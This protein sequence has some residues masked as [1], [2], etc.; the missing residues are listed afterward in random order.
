[1]LKEQDNLI[2]K[3]TLCADALLVGISFMWAFGLRDDFDSSF[4]HEMPP[5]AEYLPAMLLVIPLWVILLSLFG[6]YE[7]MREKGFVRIFWSIFEASLLATLVFAATS[8]LLKFE[9]LSRTFVLIFFVLTV[10]LLTFEK[11][12]TLNFLRNIRKRG[13]NFHS[14]IIVGSGSRARG[15]AGNVE[16]HP[17]WGFKI[18]GFI[19]E[20]EMLGRSVGSSRVIGTFDN[21]ARILDENVVDE[22]VFI[23][24]RKWLDR[25]ETQVRIC[26]KVGVK[27]TISMD[28]FDTSI[29]KPVLKDLDGWPLLTF[30]STPNDFFFLSL[31]RI[32]DTL[33]SVGGLVMLSPLFLL[34]GVIIKLT[35]PG[36]VFF[37]QVRCG[38][39]GRTFQILKFRT[40]VVDAEQKK[41]D[42]LK[43]NEVGGPVFKIK[44]DPRITSI[45]RLL[46]K[47]SL[48]EL[49]QLIN[50]LRGDMSLVG[51]RPPLPSEVER[52]ERWQRRRLSMRPGITCI[53]E[54]KA[55]NNKDFNV[56]MKMDLEYIDNWRLDLDLRILA[57]TVLAVVKGTGC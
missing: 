55:R 28:I 29:A 41:E 22:V 5:F 40:M 47:T 10:L 13:L 8:F 50:V 56:W 46:R 34:V 42:L 37:R 15:F 45:G 36:P 39:N 18:L 26:E 4:L 35:S 31:K 7:S 20:E 51:P 25:M 33:G 6:V 14:I 43:Q 48:D 11:W 54:V 24:P 49:P 21:L 44:N 17:E 57:K 23:M 1:M 3:I 38:V 16:A 12:A 2:H 32:L 30:E 27:A 19:D 9:L 52:Y 53:H